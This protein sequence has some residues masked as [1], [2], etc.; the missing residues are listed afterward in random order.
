M[1]V[2]LPVRQ[3][4]SLPFKKEATCKLCGAEYWGPLRH[5][6][7]RVANNMKMFSCYST[8]TKL[9]AAKYRTNYRRISEALEEID[10]DKRASQLSDHGASTFF[11]KGKS[12]GRYR[13]VVSSLDHVLEFSQ[14]RFKACHQVFQDQTTTAEHNATSSKSDGIARS[15][16]LMRNLSTIKVNLI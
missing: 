12:N 7:S 13:Q 14:R 4:S 2:N 6:M 10:S 5:L 16:A 8:S 9:I 11:T 1:N 3:K 15:A